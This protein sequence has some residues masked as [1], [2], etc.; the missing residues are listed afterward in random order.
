MYASDSVITYDTY[1]LLHA[2]LW[3][4]EYQFPIIYGR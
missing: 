4:L 2:L 1:I 3:V